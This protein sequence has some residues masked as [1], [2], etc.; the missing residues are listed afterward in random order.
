MRDVFEKTLNEDPYDKTSR[1]I[2]ADW[3]SE[4]GFDDEAEFHR[5]WTED[6]QDAKEWF[7]DFAREHDVPLGDILST[8]QMFYN[9]EKDGER[10]EWW[11]LVYTQDG[12]ESLRDFMFESENRVDFWKN[13][14]TFARVEMVDGLIEVQPFSC[15]C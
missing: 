13:Y 2:Y 3:L 1:L 10:Y 11:H 7:D 15:S 14:C 12:H 4:N 5:T 8:A 9:A 6:W